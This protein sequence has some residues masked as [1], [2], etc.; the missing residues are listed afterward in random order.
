MKRYISA[1]PTFYL[2]QVLPANKRDSNIFPLN[3]GKCRYFYS[4]RYAFAAAI[5]GLRLQPGDQILVPSYNCGA[6]IDPVLHVG[7][8]PVFYRIKR[9][10]SVDIDDFLQKAGAG[11]KAA[12]VT[13]FFGFPQQLDEIKEICIKKNLPLI[14]DCAHALM[15]VH[16]G[17]PLGSY[18]DASFFSFMKSLP[19]P[20]GGAL[21]V[22]SGDFSGAANGLRPSVPGTLFYSAELLMDRT[23]DDGYTTKQAALRIVNTGSYFSART[24]K[25]FVAAF[26]KIFNPKALYLVRPD[27]YSF[28]RELATWGI[29]RISMNIINNTDFEMAA[30]VRRRNFEYLLDYFATNQRLILPFRHL[31]SGVCPLF[32]PIILDNGRVRQTLYESLKR[33]G[34]ITHPWWH[35]FHPHVPW[36]DYPDAVYLK[37]RL[38]GLPIHQDLSLRH[39]DVVMEQFDK[40][41]HALI[42]YS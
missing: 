3:I 27:T 15:S 6:E 4:S 9:D 2:R 40:H 19:V 42:K 13:H 35:R 24:A 23:W 30:R 14:E 41:Y 33:A 18:G 7:V 16:K 21:I 22:N 34:I 12:L 26:R 25:L 1:R 39:L 32:F 28:M 29:S 36:T 11:A 17:R 37:E 10:L 8:E 31:P 20:N 5:V 38:F